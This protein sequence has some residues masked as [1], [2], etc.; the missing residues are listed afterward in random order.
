MQ[1]LTEGDIT[2]ILHRA[3]RVERPNYSPSS[4]VDEGLIKYLAAFAD[5]D[6]RTALNLLELAMELSKREGMTPEDLKKSLTKTLVYDRAGDQHYDTISAFIKSM[7][8]SD[9]DAALY[10]LA[11]ML[12][13]GEDALFIARRMVVFASEDVGL[14]D[15]SML[16]LGRPKS[17]EMQPRGDQRNGCVCYGK[18]YA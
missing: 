10:Y 3:L 12:Q 13:S 18:D 1:K 16:L 15:N 17:A 2:D 8:G 4:L 11:R 14:A 6:A 5:G 7:R 9:P